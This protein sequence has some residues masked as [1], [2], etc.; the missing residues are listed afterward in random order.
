MEYAREHVEGVI[1]TETV[2]IGDISVEK[3]QVGLVE[4]GSW[5]GDGVSSGMLG[6]AFPSASS[7]WADLEKATTANQRISPVF[8][9]IYKRKLAA[10]MFS[11]ALNRVDEDPGAFV[12]G[13]FP[14]E[15]IRHTGNFA[16]GTMEYLAIDGAPNIKPDNPL[17]A[18]YRQYRMN[19]D[20]FVVQSEGAG[21]AKS[22][23][24]A[25]A[26]MS[27]DIGT[28]PIIVPK[29]VADQFNK[30]W[31][32]PAKFSPK[33]GFQ[34][35]C[36]AKSPGIGVRI[37]GTDIWVDGR[38]LV[39]PPIDNTEVTECLSGVQMSTVPISGML[40]ST[41]LKNVLAVFD[42]GAGEMRFANRI[43]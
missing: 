23:Q 6:L 16:H 40:G 20:G 37:N 34:I 42:I 7:R 1:G 17:D 25:K 13:G 22:F 19:I 39:V 30:Q 3:Q 35:D 4:R 21:S 41:F 43:R 28:A 24:Q 29:A 27:I 36:K 18:D 12:I 2:T 9:S 33:E 31:S 32:P 14:D 38:D 11:L 26:Q 5:F 15:R 10:P 8:T